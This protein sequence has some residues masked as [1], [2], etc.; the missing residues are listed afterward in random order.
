MDD[1]GDR[2]AHLSLVRSLPS[3]D[4]LAQH[5]ARL[6]DVHS[7]RANGQVGHLLLVFPTERAVQP[8]LFLGCFG[9]AAQGRDA[10]VTDRNTSRSGNEALHLVL[11]LAAKGA[12]KRWLPLLFEDLD[13]VRSHLLQAEAKA[14][15][16]S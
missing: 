13:D 9:A 15:Q 11:L 4:L 12:H 7:V 6:T 2:P 5:Q 3:D 16:H 10:F 14:L 8:L 1:Q